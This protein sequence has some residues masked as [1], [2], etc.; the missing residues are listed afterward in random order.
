MELKHSWLT[1]KDMFFHDVESGLSLDVSRMGMDE[2][3]FSSMEQPMQKAFSAMR[4]LEAG[5][6]ANPD[7]NRM[8]GHY[9]LRNSALA[10]TPEL[11]E[12]IDTTFDNILD[13]AS[14]VHNGEIRPERAE[15]FTTILSIG[16]GG[17]ALGP[18]FVASALSTPDDPMRIYFFDNTDPE[19]IDQVLAEI[20]EELRRTLCIVISKSGGTKETRNGMLEAQNAYDRLGLHF[21]CHAV[22][23]T[24]KG[25]QLDKYAQANRW[26]ARFPMWDWV[27]GR[28]SEL[29]AVGL[30]PAALEG[31]DIDDMIKGAAACDELT[32]TTVTKQNPAALLALAWYKAANGKGEK[33]MVILPYADRLML[34]SRYLQQLIMESLGKEKDLDGQVVNQGLTV[35][36]NKGSTDQHAYVQQLRDGVNNFFVTFLAVLKDRHN[37]S[38]EVEE[39]VTTGDFLS[40]FWQGT[41]QALTE[42]GRT[43]ILISIPEVNAFTIGLLIAL[44]ERAVGFYASLVNINAYHQPGVEAGKKAAGQI[45]ELQAQIARALKESGRPMDALEIAEYLNMEEKAEAVFHIARHLAANSR[46]GITADNLSA[47]AKFCYDKRLDY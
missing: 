14:K 33:D 4:E 30:L 12:E 46:L 10:P 17:S 38:M 24:G 45:L 47:A 13:F 2:N 36:G 16:I 6:I 21:G 27:G 15:R 1:F 11:K 19:G 32:R 3:F 37:S 41:R 44:Y 31:F 39:G 42:S 29:S 43:S 5:A 40:G 26:L 8:V 28:T 7:E 20:G 22:A 34:F 18:E 23:V 35:Y 25:S 9:W